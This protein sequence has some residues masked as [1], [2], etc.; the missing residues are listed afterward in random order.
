MLPFIRIRYPQ[1]CTIGCKICLLKCRCIMLTNKA[2]G[3][4]TALVNA[5]EMG[6]LGNVASFTS[7]A[8]C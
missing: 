6:N 7:F 2:R 4:A 5:S 3:T 8:Q 1:G